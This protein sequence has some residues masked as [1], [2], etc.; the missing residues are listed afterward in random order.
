[1]DVRNLHSHVLNMRYV[2]SLKKLKINTRLKGN[3]DKK[4]KMQHR[5]MTESDP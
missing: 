2:N 4:L 5:Q 1:M 3:N